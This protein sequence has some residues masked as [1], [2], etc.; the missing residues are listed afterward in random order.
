M[1]LW[2]ASILDGGALA[3]ANGV[4]YIANGS[5]LYAFDA[6]GARNCSVSGTAKT[7]MPLW[8]DVTG[9]TARGSPVI[10]NGVLFDNAPG[11]GDVYALSL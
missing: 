2:I 11:N 3:I 9:F 8:D 4:V 10:V 6:A 5:T 1:P 7:C